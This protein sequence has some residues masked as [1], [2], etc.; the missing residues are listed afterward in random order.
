ML[1][2]KTRQPEG[3]VLAFETSVVLVTEFELCVF[4]QPGERFEHKEKAFSE[5]F[6]DSGVFHGLSREEIL[7]GN[8][9]VN[10]RREK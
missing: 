6:S 3:S 2:K 4:K 5:N 7:L 1:R 10:I 8:R 9:L